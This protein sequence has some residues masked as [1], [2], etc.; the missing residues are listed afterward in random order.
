MKSTFPIRER[1]REAE[2][3]G[4]SNETGGNA[5]RPGFNDRIYAHGFP[6]GLRSSFAC[7]SN[8]QKKKPPPGVRLVAQ[9]MSRIMMG[10]V[11]CWNHR[12]PYACPTGVRIGR[13]EYSTTQDGTGT[14]RKHTHT[15]LRGF[16]K[17]TIAQT[18][19]SRAL[20]GH[21]LALYLSP[22]HWRWPDTCHLHLVRTTWNE[23]RNTA[24]RKSEDGTICRDIHWNHQKR[25][26]KR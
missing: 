14:S 16:T 8:D 3:R 18:I 23:L 2:T 12:A 19:L 10:V 22:R 4:S 1:E 9:C 6:R 11:I 20:S 7:R 21:I 17:S 24:R 13:R 26:S 5:N 15:T 25:P